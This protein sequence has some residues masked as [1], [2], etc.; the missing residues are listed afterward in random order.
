MINM[1]TIRIYILLL[2]PLLVISCYKDL[3]NYEYTGNEVITITGIEASYNKV[4]M[5][6]KITL[7]PAVTS[8]VPGATFEYFWGIYET[9]VQ[10]S[11]PKLD[12]IARTKSID[13]LVTQPAKAWVLVFGAKNTKTGITEFATSTINVITQFTRG[14]YVLKDN[15]ITTD[16]DLFL[17]PDNITPTERKDNVFS[18][19]N[20][21]SLQGKAGILGFYST[22]KSTVTGALGNTRAMFLVTDADAS[23]VNINT[24]REIR[25]FNNLFYET[26]SVKAPG[27]V[28]IGSAA[29]HFLNDGKVHSL[30]SMSSNIG[31]FGMYQLRDASNSQYNLSKYFLSGVVFD[32]YFFDQTSSSFVSA[33]GATSMLSSVTSTAASSMSS[34]NNNK[35][36]LYMGLRTFSPFAGSAV[37]EDKTD[38]SLKILSVLSGSRTAFVIVNDTLQPSQKLYTASRYTMNQDEAMM[39]FVTDNEVWSRNLA[40]QFEQLQFTPPSGEEIT[41]IRHRKYTVSADAPFNYNYVMVATKSG[42]NYKVYMF[43]KTAGNLS[44]EPAF[45]LQ[46]TGSVGDVIYISPSVSEFTY[47]NTY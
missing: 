41:F 12:T 9:S 30:Y 36:A 17:T 28:T 1:K 19:V 33:G 2:I 18:L 43:T 8:S 46:G 25:D 39:Y 31:V 20:G 21:R 27:A 3:G 22:Y 40:N 7:D 26:P 11:A 47:I 44:S 37:F 35:R 29:L 42:G 23:V 15:G 14:W 24:V 16:L 4:S 5:E 32:P 10:G 6:D 38:P 34:N 13:Y 45:V